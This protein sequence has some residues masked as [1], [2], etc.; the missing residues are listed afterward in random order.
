M[1]KC[2][3]WADTPPGQADTS[4]GRQTLPWVDTPWPGRHP[5]GQTPRADTPTLG[6]HPPWADTP[7]LR[8]PLGRPPCSGRHPLAKQTPP[9]KQAPPGQADTP[10]GRHPPARQTPLHPSGRYASYWNAF[11]Y[12]QF[13]FEGKCFFQLRFSF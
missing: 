10:T 5:P 12:L 8:T 9:A 1:G 2:P 13:R 7:L 3:P 4:L 6:R 11:L